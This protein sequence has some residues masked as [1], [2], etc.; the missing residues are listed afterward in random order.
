MVSVGEWVCVVRCACY[1]K[2]GDKFQTND[3]DLL[4]TSKYFF[5][6][7]VSHIKNNENKWNQINLPDAHN[8]NNIIFTW[9]PLRVFNLP[10]WEIMKFICRQP[11]TLSATVP[12]CS[13]HSIV[14]FLRNSLFLWKRFKFE[15]YSRTIN[16]RAAEQLNNIVMLMFM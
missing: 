16:N 8:N 6:H 13:T 12:F 9:V 7:L 4:V 2:T 11:Y 10:Q 3:H 1:V 5:F 15:W 14:S